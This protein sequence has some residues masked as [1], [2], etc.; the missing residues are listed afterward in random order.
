MNPHRPRSVAS[1]AA[2]RKWGTRAGGRKR[3][4]A[5]SRSWGRAP[6]AHQ[7]ARAAPNNPRLGLLWVPGGARA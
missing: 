4:A 7:R 6:P 1:E 5:R 2:T 3:E